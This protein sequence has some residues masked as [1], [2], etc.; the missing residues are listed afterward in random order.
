MGVQTESEDD[1][2]TEDELSEEDELEEESDES[3][4]E[5]EDDGEDDEDEGE[6][7]DDE[8]EWDLDSIVGAVVDRLG[9][10]FDSIADRRVNALLKEIR[11]QGGEDD[12]PPKKKRSSAGTET[13]SD[14]GLVR[15]ARLA[16]RE[17]LT[18][19][20]E[21]FVSADERKLAM[22]LVSIEIDAAAGRGDLDDEDE[23]GREVAGRVAKRIKDA[24]KMYE[25][26]TKQGLKRR[27]A[28]K[29]RPG[30]PKKGGQK[31]TAASELQKGADIAARIRPQTSS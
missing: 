3:E 12:P 10:R 18:D 24:R 14:P 22:D 31:A 26:S 19:E 2:G 20:I 27:G 23:V 9:D 1:E 25:G 4:D 11:K 5:D 7:S 13:S 17:Y 28:L 6:G 8:D 30:Q 21:S 29:G 15:A 16:A